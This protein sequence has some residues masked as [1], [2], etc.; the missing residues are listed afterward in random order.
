[1]ERLISIIENDDGSLETT[2]RLGKFQKWV[3]WRR[4]FYPEGTPASRVKIG[5]EAEIRRTFN[6]SLDLALSFIK[7][8][9]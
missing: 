5:I 1:M 7:E 3:E 9:E 6:K 8:E 2:V 4:S